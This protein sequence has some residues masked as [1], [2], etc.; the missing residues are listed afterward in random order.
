MHDKIK[1]DMMCSIHN[2]VLF[3]ML[4]HV[5]YMLC[6]G[7]DAAL[8]LVQVSEE[9][10]RVCSMHPFSSMRSCTVPEDTVMVKAFQG[11]H[12]PVNATALTCS[13]LGCSC[14][15]QVKGAGNW[16]DLP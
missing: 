15:L 5:V 11:E 6:P 8:G 4:A 10:D 2:H 12:R 16:A 7:D 13:K 9:E 14:C 1:L 3:S